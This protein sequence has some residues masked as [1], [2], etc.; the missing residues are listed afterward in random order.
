MRGVESFSIV[1]RSMWKSKRN[2]ELESVQDSQMERILSQQ[3]N[4][5]DFLEKKKLIELFKENLR[6]RQRL[7]EAHAE[8]DRR[9]WRMR[10]ADIVLYELACSSNPRGWNSLTQINCLIR[11]KRRRAGFVKIRHE[12]QS[13][14]GRSCKGLPRN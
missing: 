11:L 1:E 2:R 9:E 4:I 14:S 13:F 6:L 5:H 7:S 3:K 8:L 10:N 12:R